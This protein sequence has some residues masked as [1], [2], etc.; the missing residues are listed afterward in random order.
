MS[1]TKRSLLSAAGIAG[2]YL[3]VFLVGKLFANEPCPPYLV[4]LFHTDPTLHPYLFGWLIIHGRMLYVSIVPAIYGKARFGWTTLSAFALG[5]PLGEF[6]GYTTVNWTH[7]GWAIFI[8]IFIS[9]SIMGIA[10]EKFPKGKINL[11]SKAFYLWLLVYALLIL[12]SI[13]WVRSQFPTP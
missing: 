13:I 5:L 7:Y 1:E 6:L 8:L 11:R 2:G 12:A 10:L 4:R 3:L 9:G